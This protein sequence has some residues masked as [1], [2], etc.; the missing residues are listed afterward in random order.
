MVRDGLVLSSVPTVLI[1]HRVFSKSFCKS[2][3]PHKSVNL[4]FT[5][6][7]RR[8]EGERRGRGR[9]RERDIERERQREGESE[10]ARE[11]EGEGEEKRA[12]W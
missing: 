2:Q 1:S 6:S 5:M 11:K 8:G 3:C 4:F 9:E 12:W 7:N 10:R